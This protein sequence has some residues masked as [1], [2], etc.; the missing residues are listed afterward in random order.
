[1]SDDRPQIRRAVIE[2]A[3]TC[4]EII[5]GWLT[6]Q[7]W[8]P[9][10]PPSQDTL[11]EIIADGIPQREFWVIGS[12]VAGYLSFNAEENLIGGLYTARPG[13]GAGAA[14]LNRVKADHDVIQL[15]TH[16]PNTNA[17]RFYHREG[18]EIVERKAE[19]RGDGVPELRMEWRR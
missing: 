19:G 8:L 13:S 3:A 17:H 15:W 18:F 6:G 14:L 11:A 2:D 5:H 16:E 1:M 9:N 10:T 4:A 12:P 7:A